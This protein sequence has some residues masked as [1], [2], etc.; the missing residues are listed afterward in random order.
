MSTS[1]YV[2]LRKFKLRIAQVAKTT[3]PLNVVLGTPNPATYWFIERLYF[4]SDTIGGGTAT[5]LVGDD[6]Q[7]GTDWTAGM[8]STRCVGGA[9][10]DEFPE[11][12]VQP[13][14]E[15]KWHIDGITAG[16]NVWTNTQISERQLV[17]AELPSHVTFDRFAVVVDR[18]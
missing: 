12:F 11:V 8:D 1:L 16:E 13:G 17:A 5:L 3:G 9:A 18:P 10:T 6:P 14:E 7:K 4:R 2:E 15:V